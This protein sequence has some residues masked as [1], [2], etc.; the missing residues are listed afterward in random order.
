M[1]V[2]HLY[3][4]VTTFLN[5]L[6]KKYNSLASELRQQ[7]LEDIWRIYQETFLLKIYLMLLQKL[8]LNIAKNL[9]GYCRK[10]SKLNVL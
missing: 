8:K 2:L 6:D 10:T 7:L 5:F 9:K 3:Y 1:K 4:K